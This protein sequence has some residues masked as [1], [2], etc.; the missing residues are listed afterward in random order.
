M[1]QYWSQMYST[2]ALMGVDLKL[3]QSL[4]KRWDGTVIITKELATMLE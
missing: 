2:T 3:A 1:K 4:R